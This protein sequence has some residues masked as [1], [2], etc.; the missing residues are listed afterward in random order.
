MGRRAMIEKLDGLTA[1]LANLQVIGALRR[2]LIYLMPIILIGSFVLALL[3]LPI[4]AYQSFLLSVFGEGWRDLGLLIHKGTLQVM[5]LTALLTVGYA[6]SGETDLVKSGE[7]SP[8]MIPAV[9]FASF[10]S[11]MNH[12]AIIS[13]ETAGAAG[14][15]SAIII[16]ILSCTLFTFFYELQDRL[17]P[18]DF[19]SYNGNALIR[20][21]FRT[22]APALLTILIFS[23]ARML[24]DY[25]GIQLIFAT[26]L[27]SLYGL[28]DTGHS[29]F[30]AFL[31]TAVTHLLWFF[32]IHGGNVV[33]DALASVSV[34]DTGA[35]SILTKG[36]FD[37]Y[38]YLGGAGA[39]LGLLTALLLSRENGDKRRIAKASIIPAVFNINEILLYG[40]PIIFNPYLF[41]PF[42]LVPVLL[43]FTSLIAVSMGWIPVVTQTTVAWTTPVFL[44][45][46]LNTGSFSGAI[47]QGVNLALSILIYYPFVQMEAKYYQRNR[48][49]L[50]KNM[51]NEVQYIKTKNTNTLL[52]RHDETGY[53][54]RSLASEIK[55]GFKRNEPPLYLE[56]QPKVDCDGKVIGAEALLRWHH[57]IYGYVSPII[58]LSI[59]DEAAFTNELGT[60]VVRQALQDWQQWCRQGYCVPL[61]VNL[62]PL[63]LQDD[64]AL[65]QTVQSCIESFQVDPKYVEL[66][67]TENATIDL[68]HSTQDK[69]KKIRGLGVSISIDDFGMG[70]SSLLYLSDLYVNVVKLDIS[71]TRVITCDKHRQHI[72]QSILSLCQQLDVK[73]VAEGVETIEQFQKLRELG[74]NNFQGFYFSKSLTSEN[75]LTYIKQKGLAN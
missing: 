16:A 36:F 49:A 4:P 52:S 6:L 18:A 30:F 39:T 13:V 20:T 3:N 35:A 54:A 72:V 44:S 12:E 1:K 37:T 11:F 55:A 75:L 42:L 21:A 69:L 48:V 63:Q 56:Y 66:E 33:M 25:S 62:S 29:F 38:V 70:H 68:S 22:I 50:F 43:S 67:L 31:T 41:I 53:L 14:M 59:C 65:V 7:V 32:G 10:I 2:G 15:F 26:L 5:S 27:A 74:C 71:L 8:I 64:N 24:I 9:A 47:M 45:G 23:A 57:P 60:W 28:W 46:Y 17:L 58:A 19:T 61:S 40:L 34:E 73:V 51:V